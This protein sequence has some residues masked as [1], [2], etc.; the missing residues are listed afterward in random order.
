MMASGLSKMR[1]RMSPGRIPPTR[2]AQ[3]GVELPA[4]LVNPDREFLDQVV[5]FVIT[6]VQV[7]S[8]F[9]QHGVVLPGPLR[10]GW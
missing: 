10:C 7:L 1:D 6:D 8:V 5:V 2:Q 4:G 3:D 9:S